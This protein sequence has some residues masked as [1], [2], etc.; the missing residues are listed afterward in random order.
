MTPFETITDDDGFF[1]FD[2]LPPSQDYAIYTL[3]DQSLPGAL[4]VSLVES[5]ATGQLADLGEVET[6]WAG[7]ST[8]T[9]LSA[10]I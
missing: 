8:L 4:P 1:E 7:G 2:S 5:P 6:Q 9:I 3:L 10:Y